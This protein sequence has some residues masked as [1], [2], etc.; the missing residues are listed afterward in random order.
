MAVER[1]IFQV[2]V[3]R[4]TK[5]ASVGPMYKTIVA[6][7]NTE[8]TSKCVLMKIADTEMR[9]NAKYSGECL[10]GGKH[11][12]ASITIFTMFLTPINDFI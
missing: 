12:Y 9:R 6:D 8:I 1:V 4:C 2:Q 7:P 10:L 11:E 3:T 5:Q